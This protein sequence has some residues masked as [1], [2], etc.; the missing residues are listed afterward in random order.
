MSWLKKICN[1]LDHLGEPP[2]D[3]VGTYDYVTAQKREALAAEERKKAD[4]A[5]GAALQSE[6]ADL[7]VEYESARQTFRDTYALKVAALPK[8]K[9]TYRVRRDPVTRSFLVETWKLYSFEWKVVSLAR[10]RN[11]AWSESQFYRKNESECYRDLLKAHLKPEHL[12]AP[13]PMI[14]WGHKVPGAPAFP[15]HHDAVLYIRQLLGSP[16]VTYIDDQ[17]GLQVS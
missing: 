17:T 12:T 5:A 11:E 8:P 15:Y 1:A 14:E 13:D 3:P 7:E 16:E 10:I 9:N 6:I 2:T 4:R